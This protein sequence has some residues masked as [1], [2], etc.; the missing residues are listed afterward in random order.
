[1]FRIEM[2]EAAEGD[3]LWVEYGDAA[4]PQHL[5]IDAG[6]KDTYRELRDRLV[7]LD[8]PV[9]LFV[10]TH[11]DDDHIFG[12]LPLFADPRIDRT[13]FKDIWYNGYTHLDSTIARRPPKDVLGPLNGEIFSALLLKGDFAWNE[14]FDRGATIVVPDS[15]KLPRIELA[16]PE[17][18]AGA[19]MMT[20][21]LLSPSWESL[22]A[23][24]RFWEREIE[25][26]DLN[27]DPGD[28][29]RALEIF[30]TRTALQPDVLGG[31]LDV[32]DLLDEPY[33]HDKKEPNGSSI[34]F[35]AE[36]GGK[37]VLFTG[38]AH[39][40]LLEGS[41]E[42]LLAERNQSVLKLD[43]LKVSHHGSKNN[44]STKLLE[45]LDCRR[46]LI[47]TNGARHKH[48]DPEAIARILNRNLEAPEPTELYFNF[49]S[50]FNAVWDDQQLKDDWNYLTY[51]ASEGSVIDL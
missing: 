51:Y 16:P 43:A 11:I 30:G 14:A 8:G 41:I 1:M 35:L 49:R 13:K 20:L 46:F 42:Q 37:A 22:A 9:E 2:L 5:V 32:D 50:T 21:T 47:S 33:T 6:R 17:S 15:G 7:L 23:L 19:D 24:K 29:E 18:S 44:T 39:P 31:L 3:C 40:P 4:R 34:A 10:M 45:L 12:A 25:D 36:Y 48:P 27:L 38:D 28:A 26:L